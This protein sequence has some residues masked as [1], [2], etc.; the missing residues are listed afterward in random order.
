[1]MPNNITVTPTR[2]YDNNNPKVIIMDDVE[3]PLMKKFAEIVTGNKGNVLEVGFGLGISANFIYD[4]EIESYTCI[5]IHPEIYKNALKWAEG[6]SN[7][8][9]ILGDWINVIPTI[10]MK[11]DGIFMD[12]FEYTNF[13]KFEEY[14]L[15]IANI[16][17]ILSIFDYTTQ[18]NKSLDYV[19]VKIDK[20]EYL[21][22]V[23]EIIIYYSHFNGKSFTKKEKS[24]SLI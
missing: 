10:N 13:N 6:K 8:N 7:V 5:E 21:K 23:E 19:T 2:I 9:I 22:N 3:I 14:C 16:N 12:T 15:K 4:S 11:F 18:S 24:N 1:M 20:A 17:C